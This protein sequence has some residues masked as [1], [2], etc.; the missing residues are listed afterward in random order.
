M[1]KKK[2]KL[3]ILSI[4]IFILVSGQV[5]YS[6]Y[7]YTPKYISEIKQEGKLKPLK[8]QISD[9]TEREKIAHPETLGNEY[10]CAFE[11]SAGIYSS[12]PELAIELCS[13]YTRLEEQISVPLCKIKIQKILE[14]QEKF[15]D[16]EDKVKKQP[17]LMP[18]E[19]NPEQKSA[20]ERCEDLNGAP[21]VTL[22]INTASEE[23]FCSF[24]EKG[25]CTQHEL[26]IEYCFIEN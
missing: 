24:G 11:I 12:Q 3:S 18:D 6:L 4:V 22:N 14:A 8:K 19:L 17:G 9:C 25:K 5:V 10:T 26:N 21:R 7:R 2:K 15:S 1:E 23:I 13:K 16:L 20:W